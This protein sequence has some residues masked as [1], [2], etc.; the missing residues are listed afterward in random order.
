MRTNPQIL[1]GKSWKGEWAKNSDSHTD[2]TSLGRQVMRFV[3]HN[4]YP[5]RS[6]PTGPFRGTEKERG[7][8]KVLTMSNFQAAPKTNVRRQTRLSGKLKEQRLVRSEKRLVS[9]SFFSLSFPSL[10]FP[11]FSPYL[12]CRV[13]RPDPTYWLTPL[14]FFH[15]FFS[16]LS[17]P[18]PPIFPRD[19]SWKNGSETG[20]GSSLI[21]ERE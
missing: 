16:L 15:P 21:R 20:I 12:L 10:V 1:A 5:R 13:A 9:S 7:R 4:D 6:H 8:Q 18:N 2:G 11:T 19:L 14:S 17:L 3:L